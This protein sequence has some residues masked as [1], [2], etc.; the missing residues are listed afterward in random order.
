MSSELLLSPG[1][2]PPP[3]EMKEEEEQ[4]HSKLTRE[5]KNPKKKPMPL[6]NPLKIQSDTLQKET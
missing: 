4:T 6:M 1:S 2:P 5:P 3:P